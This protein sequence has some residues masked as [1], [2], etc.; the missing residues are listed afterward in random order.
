MVD[1]N[2]EDFLDRV[3]RSG[4]DIEDTGRRRLLHHGIHH[5]KEI[6]HI[7]EVA[8]RPRAEATLAGL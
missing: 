4:R 6:V 3:A 2:I 5:R 1:D 8:D 7:D